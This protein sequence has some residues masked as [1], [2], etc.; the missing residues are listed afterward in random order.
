MGFEIGD[1]F[2]IVHTCPDV[3][4]AT[5]WYQRN[6]GGVEASPKTYLDI[7]RRWAVFVDLGGVVLEPMAV[8]PLEEGQRPTPMQRF[9]QTFGYRWH[10]LAYY[11][12]GLPELHARLQAAGVRMFKTGGGAVPEGP[13]AHDAGA[14]WTHPRDTFGLIEFAG[15]HPP[16]H[17]K[18]DGPSPAER[19]GIR[20]LA[21]ISLL[22]R[23]PSA[24]RRLYEDVL[25]GTVVG[26][27]HWEWYGTDSLY[28]RLGK[29][30]VVELAHPIGDGGRAAADMASG[31][32]VLHAVTLLVDRVDRLATHL[33][34]EGVKISR[35][36][37]DLVIDAV[38]ATGA[39][40]RFTEQPAWS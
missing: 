18:G 20:G 21:C 19:L 38:D 10:S 31:G 6:L 30:A 13:L 40:L 17:A 33:E 8:V 12:D 36:G 5:S 23:D 28:V 4:A 15:V 37:P 14:I 1:I 25:G 27:R 9:A 3:D 35:N 22:P 2:H 26:E 7:E 39:L 29:G 24:A 16:R 34:G 32:D 11:V